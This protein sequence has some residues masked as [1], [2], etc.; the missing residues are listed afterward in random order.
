M[1]QQRRLARPPERSDMSGDPAQLPA[2]KRIA[3]LP[4][5]E[6]FAAYFD[7]V[8]SDPDIA[9]IAA[10][11]LREQGRSGK[12]SAEHARVLGAAVDIAPNLLCVGHLGKALASLGRA[13]APGASSLV[14]R[15]REAFIVND[16]DYW[17]FDGCVWALGY[18]G[19]AEAAALIDE[20]D[21]EKPRRALRSSSV[22]QGKMTPQDRA[23]LFDRALAAARELLAKADPGAWRT[24]QGKLTAAA[25]PAPTKTKPWMSRSSS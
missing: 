1:T 19:G 18:L 5:E 4:V 15:L 16:V 22:Y 14:K 11:A 20:L 12:L 23:R 9:D 13:G 10:L 25:P 17:S 24:Q 21:R 6:S 2:V 8:G 3:A 7:L